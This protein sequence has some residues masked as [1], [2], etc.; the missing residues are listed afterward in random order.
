M[1]GK[2]TQMEMIERTVYNTGSKVIQVLLKYV[3]GTKK[4]K[5]KKKHTRFL[6]LCRS[7]A[8]LSQTLQPHQRQ[9]TRLPCPSVSSRVCSSSCSLKEKT[10]APYSSTLAW[11]IPGME[12]PGGL[13]SMGSLRI[14]HN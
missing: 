8:K 12:E 2:G 4:Q 13:Q 5:T 7:V 9:H 14:G 11:K 1:P 6:G 3:T 10:M